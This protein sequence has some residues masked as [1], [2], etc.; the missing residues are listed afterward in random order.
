MEEALP[1]V[2]KEWSS[3]AQIVKRGGFTQDNTDALPG[4]VAKRLI[5]RRCVDGRRFEYRL[6]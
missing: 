4:L 2:T 5:L 3:A 1:F 6:P